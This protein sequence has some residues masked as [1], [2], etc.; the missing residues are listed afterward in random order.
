MFLKVSQSSQE[1]S[2]TVSFAKNVNKNEALGHAVSS[3]LCK[4]GLSSKYK[5]QMCENVS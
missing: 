4:I 1:N 5:R 2:L 3:E